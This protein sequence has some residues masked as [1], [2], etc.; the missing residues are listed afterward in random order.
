M[1][2][3]DSVGPGLMAEKDEPDAGAIPPPPPSAVRA[4]Y[5]A[6]AAATIGFIPLH[7][8]WALGIPLLADPDLFRP[9]HQDGG[10]TYLW[11]LSAMALLPAVLAVALVRPWGLTFPSWVPRLGGHRVPR[12]LLIVPGA[13][14]SLILFAYTAM[15]PIVLS[16]QWNDPAAI[17][18][19][20]TVVFGIADFI[21]WIGG[22]AVATR[23]YARRTRPSTHPTTG[24]K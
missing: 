9:W 15:A 22:L 2:I 3:V 17:F 6:A 23:S 5:A 7:L 19:V 20:W 4:A 14:L 18:N 8:I 16:L 11:A 10:G 13:G 1:T 12:M 24:P 21:V